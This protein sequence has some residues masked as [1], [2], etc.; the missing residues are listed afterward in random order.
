MRR[1]EII[2]MSVAISMLIFSRFRRDSAEISRSALRFQSSDF[3]AMEIAIAILRFG[4]LRLRFE[5][6]EY[7]Y[8]SALPK[9]L[10][11]QSRT[12]AHLG[13]NRALIALGPP[14]ATKQLH[15]VQVH[16][17]PR[18]KRRSHCLGAQGPASPQKI[19]GTTINSGPLPPPPGMY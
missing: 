12:C 10:F 6:V 5:L 9:R 19:S 3:I 15:C 7:A 17:P 1:L 16:P 11:A 4:H 13:H 2:A 8:V 14:P 18:L